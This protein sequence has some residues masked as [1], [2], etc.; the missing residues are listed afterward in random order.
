MVVN[1]TGTTFKVVVVETKISTATRADS[2]GCLGQR[3]LVT[4][5]VSSRAVNGK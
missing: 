3:R 4:W 1:V 5:A 2:D